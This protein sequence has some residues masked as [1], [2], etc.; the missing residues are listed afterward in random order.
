MRRDHR[1]KWLRDRALLFE[2]WWTRRFLAPQFDTLGRAPMIVRPWHVEI[3][4]DGITAGAHLNALASHDSPIRLTTW[5]AP[6]HSARITLGDSVLL[7]GGVRL[8]AAREITVG[9]G[10][11]FAR[12]AIVTDCDWHG[13]YDRLTA[14]DNAQ[15]VRL[16]SN[17]WVGDGAY[18]GK[19][20]SIGENAIVAAR[21]VVVKDVP[22]NVV[23][24]GN[25]AQVVKELDP[26]MPRRTRLDLHADTDATAR[27]FEDAWMR[28]HGRNTFLDWLRSKIAPRTDD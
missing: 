7:T 4:G 25:P 23:V 9:D 8:L 5:P 22:A 13:V 19:G 21:A 10:S 20:V 27:F 12:G 18:V 17:V 24:A 2:A 14:A 28:Q 26:T 16:A 11:M 3:F 15:P 1:P 6:G